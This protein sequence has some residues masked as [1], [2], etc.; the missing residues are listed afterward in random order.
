[1]KIRTNA[2]LL[3]L[4]LMGGNAGAD[5]IAPGD[6]T[7]VLGPNFFVD[8]AVTGGGDFAATVANFN[9]DFTMPLLP[10]G[11]GGTQVTINGIGWACAG[12]GV[13][14]TSATVTISYLGADGVVGGGDDVVIGTRTDNATKVNYGTEYVWKFTTPMN[15]IITGTASATMFRVSITSTGGTISYKTT[16]AFAPAKISVAGSGAAVNTVDNDMDGLADSSEDGGGV[17]QSVTMTGT[18]PTKPDT[19]G[20]GLLD[21]AEVFGDAA[22]GFT[23]DPNK[24]DTDGDGLDDKAEIT[25]SAN[26]AYSNEATNPNKKD[27]DG[28]GLNDNLE[29]AN[30]TNP[31]AVD[32]DLDGISDGDEVLVYMT[33]PLSTDTD[34]DGLPDGWEIAHGLNP[35][36]STGNDGANGDPDGDMLV[37]INEYNLGFNSTDPQDSDSDNDGLTDKFEFDS[38]GL[39]QFLDPNRRD[40]DNDGL[41]DKYE[42]DNGLDAFSN[43]DFDNDTYSDFD[44]VKLYGSNPKDPA[45]F[46]GDG[47]APAV[48]SF[49]PIKKFGSIFVGGTLPL[50]PMAGDPASLNTAIINEV[51]QGGGD[52]NF[53]SGI[54][55]FTTVYPNIIQAAGTPVSITGLSL[56]LSTGGSSVN[57]S[58]DILVEFYDPQAADGNADFKGVDQETLVG[59][60]KGT[61]AVVGATGV[62]YWAFANPVNFTSAGKSLA[63]RV[64]NTSGL[65]FKLDGGTAGLRYPN[66]GGAPVDTNASVRY[67][68]FGTGGIIAN[69]GTKITSVAR[70]G[71]SYTINFTGTP[72]AGATFKVL[73]SPDL[74]T[75]FAA[76]AVN[77]QTPIAETAPGIYSVVLDVSADGPKHFYRI[78]TTTP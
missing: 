51:R 41:G 44:E 21:G 73:G 17:Y 47:T 76:A 29:I 57:A 65:S 56:V 20:D 27:T 36:V 30:G 74:V 55:S 68:L 71:N 14:A 53:A 19:D 31:N 22:T 38:T 54:A 66:Q 2:F 72:A 62:Y 70:T 42:I 39:A 50:P 6:V 46:P 63:V 26:G 67:T 16:S 32:T 5:T 40:F 8:E 64:S 78:E 58:G 18:D 77:V 60:A 4:G 69:V 35:T 23:S 59:T 11:S 45:S 7:A 48:G 24:I 3:A 13:L 12:N 28:D 25:G 10:S 43:A 15:Q 49:T 61:L 1:M 34:G 33:N 9:R 37:N 75:P 52:V